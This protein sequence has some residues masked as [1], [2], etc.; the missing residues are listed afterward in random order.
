MKNVNMG[1]SYFNTEN[2]GK[3]YYNLRT[4]IVLFQE[5]ESRFLHKGYVRILVDGS[6]KVSSQHSL[7]I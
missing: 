7:S 5:H 4:I 2:A 3:F 1:K 6:V